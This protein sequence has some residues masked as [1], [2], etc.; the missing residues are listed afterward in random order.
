M[1]A[2]LR[3]RTGPVALVP[4]MGAL[5]HGHAALIK[6]ARGAVGSDGTVVVSIFVNPLQFGPKEDLSRYPRPLSR[7]LALCRSLGVDV[8][9]TPAAEKIIAPDASVFV[10]ESGALTTGLCGAS[11]PGHFRGVCTIVAKLF[12]ITAPDIA[13][14]GEKDWQQLAVI[15]RMVRD[16]D[17]GIRIIGHPIV[18]EPDG[19]AVSS[20]NVYL[21]PDERRVAPQIFAALRA[22]AEQAT[23][24]A[25]RKALARHLAKI[26]GARVDYIEVVHPDTL[27]PIRTI[28][29]GAL[30]A[31]ALFL[32]RTRLIDNIRIAASKS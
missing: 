7:D 10:D 25:I 24:A 20:R 4:T 17:F 13:V 28:A 22:S 26:P 5:H 30:V 1:R 31:I 2:V 12:N 27:A 19:L 6:R 18:R 11:R 32:G 21:S 16:L 23:P 29:D 9:F 14:F 8:V 3:A 15:R